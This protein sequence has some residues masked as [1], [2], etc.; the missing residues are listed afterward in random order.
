[1]APGTASGILRR[2]HSPFFGLGLAGAFSSPEFIG[3]LFRR[4]QPRHPGP[5]IGLFVL[6]RR[7]CPPARPSCLRACGPCLRAVC[8]W[9]R[10][11]VLVGFVLDRFLLC[12]PWRAFPRPRRA[13][14]SGPPSCPPRT[15]PRRRRRSACRRPC[16][17]SLSFSTPSLSNASAYVLG[18]AV[19]QDQHVE[20][21]HARVLEGVDAHGH[22]FHA[23]V[24]AEQIR[25][26]GVG[27]LRRFVARDERHLG[28]ASAKRLPPNRGRR[29]RLVHIG[30]VRRGDGDAELGFASAATRACRLAG[31]RSTRASSVPRG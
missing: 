13:S 20:I 25:N 23:H 11:L 2:S 1:M 18:V 16:T 27:S 19:G 4:R 5:R 10:F 3:R 12:L 17:N 30:G 24:L 14:R 28:H 31:L 22:E 29:C 15:P 9:P 8:R 26:L 21:R 6:V 7:P